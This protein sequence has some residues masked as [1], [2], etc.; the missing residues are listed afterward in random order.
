[1]S[2]T[3]APAGSGARSIERPGWPCIPSDVVFT[4]IAAP[5]SGGTSATEIGPPS[6]RASASARAGVRLTSVT[7]GQPASS[8]A[9]AMARAEPPAPRIT[10]G[11][12]SGVQPGAASAQFARKPKPS[13]LRALDDAVAEDQRVHRP[14]AVGGGVD[15]VADR[16]GGLLVRDG[17]IGAAEAEIGQAAHG[18]GEGLRPHRQGE[19]GAVDAVAAQPQPVQAGGAGMADGPAQDAGEAGMAGKEGAGEQ[20]HAPCKP[21]PGAGVNGP[22]GNGSGDRSTGPLPPR[23]ADLWDGNDPHPSRGPRR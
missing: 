17:H 6:A 23:R 12:A 2:A 10:T 22:A 14:G 5:A 8:S 18:R 11:P 15:L 1:M 13:V 21:P 4:S 16:E 7:P 9:A 3:T 20:G 19:I